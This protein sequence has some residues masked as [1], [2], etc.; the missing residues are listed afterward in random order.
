[1]IHLIFTGM[2]TTTLLLL[3]LFLVNSGSAETSVPYTPDSLKKGDWVEIESVHYYPYV[4]PGIEE[5][6]PWR[7]EN[8]RRV[9]FKA[10]VTDLNERTLTLDYTF[11]SLYDCRNDTG[12]PGFYYFDSRYQQ[13][14]TFDHEMVGKRFL[15]VTYDRE[16][17]KAHTLDRQETTFSYSKNYVPFGVRQAGLSAYPGTTIQDSLPLDKQLAPAV[18]DILTGW[19]EDGMPRLA[20]NMRVIDASFSLPPN[21]EFTCSYVNFDLSDDSTVHKKIFIAY[22]T[23][24]KV[25][26]RVTLLL[27]PGDSITQDKELFATTHKRRYQGRGSEQ[28]NFQYSYRR[29]ADLYESDL[30]MYPSDLESPDKMK[31]AFQLR[32]SLFQNVL[33][34]DFKNMDPYWQM[35]FERSEQYLKGALA[36]HLYMYASDKE[37]WHKSGLV[38]WQ[39]PYFV[40]VNPLIDFA[41]S[42]HRPEVANYFYFLNVYTMYKKQELK[43]D[44]L[45]L[46]TQKAKEK[47]DDY[48]LNKHIL[49]GFPKYQVNGMNLQFLMH[50]K[51]LA[52]TQEDYNDFI[53]SCPDTSLTNQLRRAYDKL[54]PFE[55]GKNIR[56]S[57]L[58]IADS[59][60]LVKGSDRKYILLFLSTREQGLP[61]PSLQN[62]LDFKKRLESEGLA[63]IVQLELYSKFQSNNAKRVK[64]FKTISDLQIEELRR[65]ELGTVTILMREDG[66]ILHRQF[67]NW[68]FDPSPALEI[69]Q[70]DLKREDESF[71]DFLKGFKEGV[72]GTLLIAA[73]IG[74]SYYSRVKGKQ[75]KERNRRRIRELELRAIR[76]Q[77]N[78]HFIFNALSSIQNLINRSANQEANK[79]L[80]DFSRLLR[81][82][83]ATSEKKLVP[84]SDEIEQLQL[85]LKLEQ[86]RFPFSYSL[87]VD[88]NI[89]PDAIE[90]PGMLIQPFVENAVKHGIAPRGTGEIIIRLSL[91]DQLLVIDIIDD[92]PGM[93]TETESGF[94]IRA[95]SN[96]FEI[97]KDL[98]NTEIGITIENRQKKE[99]VS[100]CHVRLSIPL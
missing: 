41:Y 16:S 5:K 68:Q 58:K 10:T 49:S 36:L 39:A 99:S 7:A 52:E 70:N 55:A 19:Q 18:Q 95:I 17:R 82:V 42:M 90:I 35:V 44:N 34:K 83:L 67:T 53:R 62:A 84:L 96:E 61:A 89:E 29:F 77:M 64:P 9:I 8:I 30:Y 14:F 73:I 100:G 4:T 79:Y 37:V 21:T 50:D 51:T 54:L 24:H 25:G 57:G 92:G 85:Y 74:I 23:E 6:V 32:E 72:L 76:S 93:V 11:K 71:N 80:I 94:G 12:K 98:Y 13:D 28:N 45:N 97:L 38:D 86:L 63:S 75:K 26:E 87:T 56:E 81:K 33:A 59:L 15:R 66:T 60:H 27:T 69:I 40:S 91:Q 46:K 88:N 1:M 3:L 31:K 78:P 65:K 43:A 48:Y 20:Q 2:K 47:A 22:P